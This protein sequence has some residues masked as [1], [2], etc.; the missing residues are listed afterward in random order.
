[1]LGPRW[2]AELD[3]AWHDGLAAIGGVMMRA[4]QRAPAASAVSSR[5][6]GVFL[7]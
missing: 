3:D 5:A 7:R 6:A 1:V 2:S 4:H